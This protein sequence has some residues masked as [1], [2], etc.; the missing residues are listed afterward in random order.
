MNMKKLKSDI[1]EDFYKERV[2]EYARVKS[3]GNESKVCDN[4]GDLDFYILQHTKAKILQN[5]YVRGGM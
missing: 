2:F 1:S 3:I 4:F 5:N